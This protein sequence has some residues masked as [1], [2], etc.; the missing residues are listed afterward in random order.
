MF[1]TAGEMAKFGYLYRRGGEWDGE[2]LVPAGG[3]DISTTFQVQPIDTDN[4]GRGPGYSYHWWL[5]EI[6]GIPAFFALGYGESLID[7]VP[8]LDLVITAAIETVPPLELPGT[9]ARPRPVIRETILPGVA[10]SR[11]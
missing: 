1:L 11:S 4:F 6:Q 5:D 3:I 10:A 2:Q 9:Q 8:S 7:V